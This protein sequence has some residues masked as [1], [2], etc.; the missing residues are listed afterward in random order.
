MNQLVL[1]KLIRHGSLCSEFSLSRLDRYNQSLVTGSTQG[2]P[3]HKVG[4][5][6][7]KSFGHR[8][9]DHVHVGV[10]GDVDALATGP[11]A[12]VK[13]KG[14]Y[15]KLAMVRADVQCG[16]VEALWCVEAVPVGDGN[17]SQSPLHED[18]GRSSAILANRNPALAARLFPR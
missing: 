6:S 18:P 11:A 12:P 3:G 10:G 1:F 15:Q 16:V 7:G 5:E 13:G 4:E 8:D 17:V 2:L 9:R 14:R